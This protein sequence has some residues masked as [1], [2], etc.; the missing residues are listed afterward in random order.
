M[1]SL[2]ATPLS[3]APGRY[4]CVGC[5]VASVQPDMVRFVTFSCLRLQRFVHRH[6]RLA[7]WF[8]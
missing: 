4:R 3:S 2:R 7:S 5:T 8:L 6:Q 1:L